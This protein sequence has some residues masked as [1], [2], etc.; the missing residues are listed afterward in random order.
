MDLFLN[1]P[2]ERRRTLCEEAKARLG[3]APA[4]VE[5]DFW[6]CWTLREL[7]GLPEW[8]AHLTFKGGTSLSKAWNLIDRFSED[9]DIVIDRDFLG[10]GGEM[11]PEAAPSRKQRR[12]RLE[13]L[14]AECQ[15]RI[16]ADLLPALGARFQKALPVGLVW[17]LTPATADEDPDQQTLL[18]QYPSVLATVSG[19]VRP[20]VKI[21]M[22]ARSD[23]EPAESP[24]I[25]PY[26]ADAFPALLGPSDVQVRALAPERTF[27]EKAMLLHE[28]THRPAG[29]A[30]KARLARHYHDLWCLITKGVAARAVAMPGLF[31][32]VAAHREVF[33]NWSWMDYST[34][35]PG[36]LRLLPLE[37][38]LSEWRHDYDSMG[39][40]M[41]V[42]DVPAFDE[43][44]R[45]VG[46]FERGFNLR[47]GA[48]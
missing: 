19:Y 48:T 10:F 24:A 35:R 17:S 44:L 40:E 11:S 20:V 41:F 15:K 12:T 3:L 37:A 13:A 26:L 34:L 36:K 31:E 9:I 46:E 16:H 8:G 39:R 23:T 22:G 30:R 1:L 5:K 29:K 28:E 25:R 2:D 33:F 21:E 27:W 47:S 18:F 42:G 14:K 38:Q 6:V 43:I 7:F 4:N 32:R 45:V